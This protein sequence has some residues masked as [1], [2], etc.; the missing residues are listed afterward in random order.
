[1]TT[2]G[3]TTQDHSRRDALAALGGLGLLAA[4][5]SAG[6]PRSASLAASAAALSLFD[7]KTMGWDVAKNQ[8]VLPDLPYEYDALEPHIDAQTMKIHHSKHHAGYVRGLNNA[9]EQLRKIREGQADAGMV[10]HWSQELAFHGSGHVN[11]SIFWATMA[12]AGNGGGG[13]PEGPL[14]ERINRD[15]GSFSGF[16]AHF[17]AAAGSVEGSGWAWLAYE[18][19]SRKL[20]IQQMEKQQNTDMTGTIPLLGVDVWE[21]AYYLKYQNRRGEYVDNFMRIINWRAVADRFRAVKG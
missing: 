14:A 20:V 1:M 21:H 13:Y 5:A 16:T 10:K 7:D 18:P 8:Y 4:G 9:L 3:T 2:Q 6:M 17:K 11:H 15:F 19:V 12:P